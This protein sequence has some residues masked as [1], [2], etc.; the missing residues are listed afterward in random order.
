[1]ASQGSPRPYMV[2]PT[3]THT[4]CSPH[5][6][7]CC[8]HTDTLVFADQVLWV[9]SRGYCTCFQLTHLLKSLFRGHLTRE[10]F[11]DLLNKSSSIALPFFL[12]IYVAIFLYSYIFFP[13][14]FLLFFTSLIINFYGTYQQHLTHFIY[15]CFTNF[16]MAHK[17][18][19]QYLFNF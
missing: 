16:F 18:H 19:C 8:S 1:M 17:R 5:G 13:S 10:F 3:T 9:L 11:P 2:S 6:S 4:C 12:C 7:S 15:S 14:L